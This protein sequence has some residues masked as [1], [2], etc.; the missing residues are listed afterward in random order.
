MIWDKQ[1]LG[2]NSFQKTVFGDYYRITFQHFKILYSVIRVKLRFIGICG[3]L[4]LGFGSASGWGLA[5]GAGAVG[6]TAGLAAD[7]DTI[8]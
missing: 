5:L 1:I 6:F 2:S 3:R 4:A 7:F 8:S